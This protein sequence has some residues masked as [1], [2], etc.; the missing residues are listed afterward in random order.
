MNEK[1]EYI[2]ID[3]ASGGY[4]YFTDRLDIARIW[5][6][7]FFG[8]MNNYIRVNK[9]SN[10]K[11]VEICDARKLAKEFGLHDENIHS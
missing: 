11:P 4:P 3:D 6:E 1:N 9:L 7:P 5:A 8:A 2:A 10:V